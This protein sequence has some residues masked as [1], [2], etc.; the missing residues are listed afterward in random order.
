MVIEN[1]LMRYFLEKRIVFVD[2]Y[3]RKMKNIL[4]CLIL[5]MLFGCSKG[6]KNQIQDHTPILELSVNKASEGYTNKTSKSKIR[7]VRPCTP[8]GPIRI[9][10]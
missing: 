1:S 8:N 4:V 7:F 3:I 2:M 9:K 6:N 10:L 5:V